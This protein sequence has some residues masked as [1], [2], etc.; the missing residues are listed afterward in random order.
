MLDGYID[1]DMA[2]DIDSRKSTL[3]SAHFPS[4]IMSDMEYP[5][6]N[7]KCTRAEDWSIVPFDQTSLGDPSEYPPV[8]SSRKGRTVVLNFIPVM[9]AMVRR[10]YLRQYFGACYAD[11]VR[12][13]YQDRDLARATLF[14]DAPYY[15]KFH[16]VI[17][18]GWTGWV[19]HAS[20]INETYWR[21]RVMHK[22][23]LGHG[24]I[25]GPNIYHHPVDAPV[26]NLGFMEVED[27]EEGSSVIPEDTDDEDD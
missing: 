11:S 21:L 26:C 25:I 2:G 12:N 10:Y 14:A 16:E 9:K 4:D 27:E 15:L 19:R 8:R 20:W 17:T 24:L 5:F 6:L 1:I 7:T 13:L 23:G 18:S 3:G 22:E